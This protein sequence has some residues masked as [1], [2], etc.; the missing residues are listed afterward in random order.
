MNYPTAGIV[1]LAPTRWEMVPAQIFGTKK[2][3]S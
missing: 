1:L 3:M 2:F